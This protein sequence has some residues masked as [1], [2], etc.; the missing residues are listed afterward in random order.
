MGVL[1]DI[2]SGLELGR[3]AYRNDIA[4]IEKKVFEEI[5]ELEEIHFGKPKKA[6]R[7]NVRA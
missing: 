3:E 7:I 6:R 2:A 1:S 5:F 4:E